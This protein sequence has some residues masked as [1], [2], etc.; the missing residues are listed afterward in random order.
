M[1][2]CHALCYLWTSIN[3]LKSLSLSFSLLLTLP[4]YEPYAIVLPRR[5]TL[6]FV[7]SLPLL[8]PETLGNHNVT[9]PCSLLSLDFNQSLKISFL[10]L[11]SSS[12]TTTIWALGNRPS[13]MIHPNLRNVMPS[14][15]SRNPLKSQCDC[16]M[17]SLLSLDF[18]QSLKLYLPPCPILFFLHC[19]HMSPRQSSFL[20]DTP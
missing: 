12:Y 18:S 3:H 8:Y 10:V 7:T 15:I 14:L 9:L 20:D 17:L 1:W 11:F 2:L 6:T 16:A 19:Q 5:Y 13:S 4:T